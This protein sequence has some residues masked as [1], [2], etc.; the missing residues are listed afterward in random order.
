MAEPVTLANVQAHLSA[1]AVAVG[2]GDYLT[3]KREATL[4]RILVSGI[5][6]FSIDGQSVSQRVDAL[7]EQ[8]EKMEMAEAESDAGGGLGLQISQVRYV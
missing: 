2:A 8:I 4:V 5:P 7:F 6:D 1:A 3:A